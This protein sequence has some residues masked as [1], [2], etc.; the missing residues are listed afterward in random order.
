[1]GGLESGVLV[2]TGGPVWLAAVH[3]QLQ[4]ND[5]LWEWFIWWIV[6]VVA[7]ALFLRGVLG[8]GVLI[9]PWLIAPVQRLALHLPIAEVRSPIVWRAR[10]VSR[11]PSL[12]ILDFEQAIERELAE[13]VKI[14]NG[15]TK[16]MARTK[17]FTDEHLPRVKAAAG[18]SV[19]RKIRVI[20]AYARDLEGYANR[21]ERDERRLRLSSERLAENYIKRLEAF[22]IGSD[23]T[24][25]QAQF[26]TMRTAAIGSRHSLD[27]FRIAVAATRAI[28]M[29]R[30]IN[31]AAD[32]VLVGISRVLDVFDAVIEFNEKA[33]QTID[34]KLPPGPMPSQPSTQSTEE[35][36]RQ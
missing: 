7:V 35:A 12:G 28:N 29:H 23:L 2:V 18:A 8:L 21:L 16:D 13:F 27:G 31:G 14:L 6:L 24:S 22:P 11:E 5:P 25:I 36:P 32:H 20:A 4:P 26:Q 19:G 1:M 17:R 15:M 33:L 9:W 34:A 3:I 30:T 10:A